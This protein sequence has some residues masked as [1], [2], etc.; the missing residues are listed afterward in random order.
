MKTPDENLDHLLSHA[1]HD[2][3]P[4]SWIHRAS[5]GL[6]A[7]VLQRL[8]RPQSWSEALFSLTSWR[9]LAAAAALVF[10][11]A[12][13]TGRGVT[14]VFDDDWLS[15]QTPDATDPASAGFDY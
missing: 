4:D 8:A 2:P 11:I 7:R 12:A 1:A 5:R 10:A 14:D 6:E 3:R 13:F 15:L 9:P